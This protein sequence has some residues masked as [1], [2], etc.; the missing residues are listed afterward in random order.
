MYSNWKRDDL[1]K[2]ANTPD[3]QRN[4]TSLISMYYLYIFPPHCSGNVLTLVFSTFTLW[5]TVK[6]VGF[7]A[8]N[9][10]IIG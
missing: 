1:S 4:G 2:K 9:A 7:R 10:L 8:Q 6:M 5:K 3:H